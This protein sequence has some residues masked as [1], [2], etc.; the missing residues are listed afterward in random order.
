MRSEKIKK[1]LIACLLTTSA[2]KTFAQTLSTPKETL[3]KLLILPWQ[4]PEVDADTL[5]LTKKARATVMEKL[6]QTLVP[7]A[8]SLDTIAPKGPGFETV[9]N[10]LKDVW[11]NPKANNQTPIAVFP[12]WTR[13]H[14]H[15][16]VA[17]VAVDSLQNTIRYLT[18]RVLP[19]Q[20]WQAAATSKNYELFFNPEFSE[21]ANVLKPDNIKTTKEDMAVAFVDQTASERSNEIDRTTLDLFLANK[22]AGDPQ[23]PAFAVINPFASELLTSIQKLYKIDSSMRKSNRTVFTRIT[24]D[25]TPVN[26]KLPLVLTLHISAADGVFGQTLPWSWS[27]HLT[28]KAKNDNTLELDVSTKLQDALNAEKTSLRRDELPQISKIRGAWAYV[29]KGRAWGLRMN[30]RLMI[31]DGSGKIKGHVV[32]YFGPELKL[33]SPRGW[34][35]HEGAIIF[36]R[37]GQKDIREGQSLMYDPMK[38]P[39]R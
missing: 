32:G 27:E 35:I 37:K 1:T 29:D 24:Y 34:P 3:P 38:V 19:S 8:V 11:A 18:H 22:I 39:A 30:D 21:L 14:D 5:Q 12:L 10:T 17:L 15:D 33:K 36:I 2:Q 28:V 20:R 31:S 7:G 6:R 4:T 9:R 23:S 16:L 13:L 26:A 25:K